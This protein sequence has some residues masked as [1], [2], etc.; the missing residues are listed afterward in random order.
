[1]DSLA[2]RACVRNSLSNVRVISQRRRRRDALA[3]IG[4]DLVLFNPIDVKKRDT[5]PL[6]VVQSR[7]D[8]S[9]RPCAPILVRS[10]C[11]RFG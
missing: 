1:M 3:V 2:V 8:A 11:M 6:D 7:S 9:R 5:L 10:R 4:C